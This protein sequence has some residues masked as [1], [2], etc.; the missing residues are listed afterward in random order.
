MTKAP[1]TGRCWGSWMMPRME[2]KMVAKA[3]AAPNS[4]ARMAKVV[5]VVMVLLV[6]CLRNLCRADGVWVMTSLSPRWGS[7]AFPFSTHGLR[8]YGKTR[9][10]GEVRPPRLKPA[11]I[12]GA[13]RGAKAPLF[14]GI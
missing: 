9:C 2:P 7:G 8:A 5:F 14:H 1:C 4:R 3:E 12:L 6:V 10:G 13:L 11:L